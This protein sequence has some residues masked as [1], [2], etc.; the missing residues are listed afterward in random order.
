MSDLIVAL[1]VAF[2]IPGVLIIGIAIRE[3]ILEYYQDHHH[4]HHR[5]A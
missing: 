2:I 5:P 3:F 1:T 4:D